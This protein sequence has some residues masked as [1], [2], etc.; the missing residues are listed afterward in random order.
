MLEHLGVAAGVVPVVVGVYDGG[1]VDRVGGE[2]LFDGWN[3]FGRVGWVDDHGVFGR[4]V[5]DKVGIV[6]RAADPWRMSVGIVM[7]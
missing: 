6:V 2:V 5:G 3:D 4:F 7:A 1:Q